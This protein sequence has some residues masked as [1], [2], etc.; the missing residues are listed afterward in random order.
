M[1][2][3][4]DEVGRRTWRKGIAG[5]SD[6]P[7]VAVKISGLG[8]FDWPWTR[9]SIRSYVLE[10][11]D[12]LGP[13]RGMFASNFPVDRMHSWYREVWAAFDALTEGFSADER[14]RMF[15]ANA[16]RLYRITTT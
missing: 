2:I 12:A 11:I 16:A 10:T 8:M 1:P 13:D 15:A 7:N 4:R 3:D 5:L 14:E 9:D 6:A